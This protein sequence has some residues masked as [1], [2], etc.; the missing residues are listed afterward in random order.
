MSGTGQILQQKKLLHTCAMIQVAAVRRHRPNLFTR[1]L[2]LIASLARPF[3]PN[4]LRYIYNTNT[5]ILLL[6]VCGM[7]HTVTRVAAAPL[8]VC[9]KK[10]LLKILG[11]NGL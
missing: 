5:S 6:T 4:A 7:T 9:L 11:F 8:E 1:P 2:V 3:W 10:M